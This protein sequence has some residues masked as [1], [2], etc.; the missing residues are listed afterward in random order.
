MIKLLHRGNQKNYLE[1]S[2]IALSTGFINLEYDGFETDLKLTKDNKWVL[3]HDDNL[4]RLCNVDLNLKDKNYI[5]LPLLINHFQIPLLSNLSFLKCENKI[6]NLEIKEPF[7]IDNRSKDDLINIIK[8]IDNNIII[9]SFDW[10]WY[11][12]CKKYD[13]NF[14][15]L[16]E[17]VNGNITYPKEGDLWILHYKLINNEIIKKCRNN[18]IKIGCFTLDKTIK[19]NYNIDLEIWNN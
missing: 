11:N 17:E 4:K 14:G 15:H 7:D 1:N 6:M 13:L 19:F 5:D 9:S 16:I 8:R 10:R 12:W 18:N 2:F 3:F